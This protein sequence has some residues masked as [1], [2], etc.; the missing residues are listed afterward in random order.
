M[1]KL[2][3]KTLSLFY[4]DQMVASTPND[5]T[6]MVNMGIILEKGVC[7]RRLKESGSSNSSRKYCNG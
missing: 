3:K 7:E 1:T 4:Y 2:F 6:E 5:F